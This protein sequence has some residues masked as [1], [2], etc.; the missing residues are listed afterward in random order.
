M[1]EYDLPK[2][3]HNSSYSR[4]AIAIPSTSREVKLLVQDLDVHTPSGVAQMVPLIVVDIHPGR[5]TFHPEAL[6]ISRDATLEF[7]LPRTDLSLFVDSTR[8][9]PSELQEFTWSGK[10]YASVQVRANLAEPRVFWV[11]D[12]NCGS[13]CPSIASYYGFLGGRFRIN[14]PNDTYA[15]IVD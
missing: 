9:D 5:L 14:A 4:S 10:E 2:L 7:R 12:K 8:T 6:S 11:V 3:V 13:V 15:M 1:L